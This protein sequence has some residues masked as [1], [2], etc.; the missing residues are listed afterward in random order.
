LLLR[1][2]ASA[3][4]ISVK[5]SPAPCSLQRSLKGKSLTP[6]I[7]ASTS[8]LRI[9]TEPIEKPSAIIKIPGKVFLFRANLEGV[10]ALPAA[11]A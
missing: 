7:G 8:L 9:R 11:A 10:S 4:I 3:L 2:T 5:Q 1:A 6:H